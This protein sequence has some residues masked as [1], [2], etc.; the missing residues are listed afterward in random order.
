M[1]FSSELISKYQEYMLKLHDIEISDSQAQ[2]DLKSL[3]NLLFLI[4]ESN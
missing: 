1:Q 2:L 4:T 3:S